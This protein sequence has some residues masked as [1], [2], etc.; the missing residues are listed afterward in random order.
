MKKLIYLG[1]LLTVLVLGPVMTIRADENQPSTGDGEKMG[2]KGDMDS[3][4][5]GKGR[6]EKMK[7]KLGLTDAQATQLKDLFQKQ[8]EDTKPLRD[9]VKIDMDT[10]KQKVDTKASDS[11]VKGTLDAL[12]AD[13]KAMQSDREK[14][15]EKIRTILTPTQQAKFVLGMKARGGEMMKKWKEHGKRPSGEGKDQAPAEGGDKL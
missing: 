9:Q 12:S 2:M 11:A 4:E 6:L 3:P 1:S 15:M 8:R 13:R 10:L 5:A 14:F 7:E